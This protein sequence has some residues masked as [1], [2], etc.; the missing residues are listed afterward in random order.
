[1]LF[2]GFRPQRCL[3]F[4]FVVSVGASMFAADWPRWRG[5]ANNGHV[6]AGAAVPAN[7][8]AEPTVVWQVP[9]GEG[10]SSPVVAHGRVLAYDNVDGPEALRALDVA[11]GREIWRA[12]IDTP[13][14]DTQGPTG[15]RNTPLIDDD[16]VYAVSC[17]GELQCRRFA[18]GSLVWRTSYV[19]N[20]QAVFMGERGS[21]SGATRHGNNASPLVDGEHLLVPVGGTNGA[22][23]VCFNKRSGDVVWTSTSDQAGYAPVVVA[24]IRDLDQ[25]V[26]YTAAGVVGLRRDNGR[27]LWRVPVKTTFSRHV[28]TPV[29]RGSRVVVSSHQA[30]LIGIEV[31]R[32][33]DAWSTEVAWK[34]MDAAI[35]YSSPVAVGDYLYCVGPG[36]DLICV[37]VRNGDLKWSQPGMFQT[38]SAEKTHGGF[39]A[40]GSNILALT[41]TGELL[42]FAADP[43]GFKSLG[44][45]QVVGVNWCNPA[46]ADGVL[47]LRDGL[48]K[49]GSWKAVR[50]VP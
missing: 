17:R 19:T 35:N 43:T 24:R 29:V 7:L 11:T 40:M 41:D 50:L 44:R 26:A 37:D 31:R 2:P 48:K 22:G 3:A 34:S 39:I 12:A 25:V 33:G 14:S 18:D 36:K 10:L 8:P 21:A 42:L 16:R 46:Y 30:G 38:S 4:A 47:Y 13:F 45:A 1:M 9:A 49:G 23:I 28:T 5:P 6:P 27:E 15:P 32:D 20:F